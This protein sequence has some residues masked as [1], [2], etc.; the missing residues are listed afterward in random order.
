MRLQNVLKFLVDQVFQPLDVT[1][2]RQVP[3]FACCLVSYVHDRIT[4]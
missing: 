1:S 4:L 2:N 3:G